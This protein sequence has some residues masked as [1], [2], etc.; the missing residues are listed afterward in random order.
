M[1]LSAWADGVTSCPNGL[2]DPE[3]AA[4][5]CGAAVKLLVTFGYPTR[6]RQPESRPAKEWSAR[7][8]RKPLEELVRRV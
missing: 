1:M 7:A 4:Q 5:I 2:R 3:A 8:K 6:P